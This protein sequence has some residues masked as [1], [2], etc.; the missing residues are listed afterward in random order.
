M[1]E[2]SRRSLRPLLLVL[3][4]ALPS[5]ALGAKGGDLVGELRQLLHLGDDDDSVRLLAPAPARSAAQAIDFPREAA[6]LREALEAD[7]PAGAAA[8]LIARL[9]IV[10]DRSDVDRIIPWTEH[11]NTRVSAPALNALGRIGGRR[12][13]DRLATMAR[14]ND[15]AVN[16]SATAALGLSSASE[17][18]DVLEELTLDTDSWRRQMA[19]DS[20]ALRGGARAR[21]I[22]HRAFRTGPPSEAWAVANAVALLGED[23][24]RML[25]ART[26]THAGDPRADAAMWALAT[27]SGPEMDALMLELAETTHGA[28]RGSALGALINVR[29][30]RAVEILLAAWDEGQ[31]HRY[32]VASTLGSSK[33]PGALD[34]LLDLLDRARPDQAWWVVD[35]LSSRPEKTAEQVLLVL[36]SE[37]GQV[38]QHALS[39]LA[40]TNAKGTT[41]LLIARFDSSGRLPPPDTFHHLA[42]HG[43]DEGWTLLEE[44]LAEGTANDRNNVVWALQARGD[45]DAVDR[46]LDLARTSDTWTSSTA[47]GALEGMGDDAREGLRDLLLKQVGDGEGSFDQ[48]APTLARLGGDGARDLLVAR[49]AEGTDTERWSAM[50]ALG[51][52]DDPAAR[53]AVETMLDSEEPAMR[54]QALQTLMWNG[55]GELTT[56]VL[57]KALADDDP[58]VRATAV[59]ALGTVAS[60][61]S[62]ERLF[63]LVDDEDS[64]IR[65][66]A[67]SALATSGAPEAEEVLI[68]A[69]DDP[70][71]SSTA[72]WGLQSMGTREGAEAIR[73]LAATGDL[74]QRVAAIGM[75]GNDPSSEAGQILAE[76]LQSDD[77]GEASSALWALQARGN[78]AAAEAI[79]EMIDRL[80][81]EQDSDLL[82]QAASSLQ[83]MGGSLARDRKEQLDEILG[84]SVDDALIDIHETDCFGEGFQMDGMLSPEFHF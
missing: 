67:I 75:L 7:P 42:L 19:L 69:L 13:I 1:P 41:E 48:V 59:S 68:G 36:A 84:Y 47:M 8:E 10:G 24:D 21:R 49:L 27:L 18:V 64:M 26:A 3:L 17:A 33:A 70:E 32:T 55:T 74:D 53:A 11:P 52:M 78:T 6:E 72:M 25:L 65:S 44:A 4:I 57:D 62:I 80:D 63:G 54:S 29:D 83:T 35:A 60:D 38:A 39:A 16:A 51:Q 23:V 9:G 12:A 37:D 56:E 77:S 22:I 82:I 61:E 15:T 81:P 73:G 58:S 45:G 40:R 66:T 46:L 79:A 31:T 28:R 43:G 34:A 20:L 30:P 71:L 76:R 50:S 14:S 2:Q 5:L